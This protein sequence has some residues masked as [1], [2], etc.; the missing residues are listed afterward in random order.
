MPHHQLTGPPS[1]ATTRRRVLAFSAFGLLL[2]VIILGLLKPDGLGHIEQAAAD[3]L[4]RLGKRV[5]AADIGWR[6]APVLFAAGVG[7]GLLAGMIGMGGGVLKI[8]FMLILLRFDFYFA[9]AIALVT[10]FFSS[11]TALWGFVKA[12]LP[13][14]PV[15]A[16]MLLLAVPASLVAALLGNR[17]HPDTLMMV[18]GM[19]AIFLAFNTLAFILGDPE[20]RVMTYQRS[21][22]LGER[23]RYQTAVLGGLHGA[24]CGLLGI[25][26]GV[27][28]TPMQQ[29]L[30]RM[31]LRNAIANTLVVSTAVT[32]V[33][34]SAV[35]W[36]GISSHHFA[37]GDLLFVDLCMG[38]GA[39][40]GA[41]IGN[42]LGARC[43]VTGLRLLFV[44]LTSAAGLSILL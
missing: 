39:T 14:W 11:A 41:P 15:A 37:A 20:E 21:V 5:T 29:L 3:A 27:I 28:A 1:F 6:H 23:E 22:P 2:L 40:L 30:L 42:R 33:A 34:G 4:P 43:S 26:G 13:V 25:S 32:L 12:G 8:A 19:F 10:M 36:S 7:A 17:L 38:S 9:R 44:V 16:R 18:F 35:V 31:P 24:T